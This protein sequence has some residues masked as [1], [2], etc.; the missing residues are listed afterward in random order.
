M[1]FK[2]LKPAW[3]LDLGRTFVCHRAV[4][5]AAFQVPPWNHTFEPAFFEPAV[6][7]F[8]TGA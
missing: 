2:A 8:R 5:P 1:A 7:S 6:G 4:L 3:C